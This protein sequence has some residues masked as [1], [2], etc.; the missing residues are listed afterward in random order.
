MHEELHNKLYEMWKIFDDICQRNHIT[1]FFDS[2]SAIG[3]VRE[4]D[5]IPWDDDIDV[6]IKRSE[7]ERLKDVLL[8]ELPPHYRFIEPKDYSPYFFDFVPKLL[9]MTVPLRKETDEDRAY[10]NYQNRLSIDFIILDAVPDSK[11]LQRI[12]L[13]KCKFYYGLARSKRY[14]LKTEKLSLSEMILS[15][16]CFMLGKPY[17]LESLIEKYERNTLRYRNTKS[18]TV[19][20]SNSILYFV[21]CFKSTYYDEI[22]YLPFH[23]GSAPLP[24]GYHA[25][26]TQMYGDYM[27]PKKDY[28]GLVAHTENDM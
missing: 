6:A 4:H 18:D 23:G 24:K 20:R 15:T 11:I 17:R 1:Y 19:I 3:A 2:G 12:I 8:R 14:K 25:V 27:T 26:L 9:D 10:H 5:F 28:K 13:L 21:D 22:V 16:A 7:Y